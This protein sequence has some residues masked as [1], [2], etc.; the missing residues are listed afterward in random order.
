MATSSRSF[1]RTALAGLAAGAVTIAVAELLAALLDAAGLGSGQG[2]PVLGVGDAAVDRTPGWL[3]DFAISTFG[4]HDK[5]VLL[6]S[7]GVV[8]A[9]LAAAAGV[10][11]GR[12]RGAGVALVIGLGVVAA[13]AVVTRPSAT[14][15]DAVPTALGTASGAVVLRLL[16]VRAAATGPT[17]RRA[18][19]QGA[20]AAGV[21]AVAAG[22][23]S[24]AVGRRAGSAADSRAAVRLP[25]PVERVSVPPG[26]QLPVDGITPWRTAPRDFYRVDTA[27]R[28]P[29]V[30][31]GEWSLRVHG[32]VERELV[33]TYDEL[34][35]RPLV[36]RA[37]TLTCVSN[38]V[39]GQLLGNAVWLGYPVADLLA[40]LGV[41]A[42]ADMVLSTSVD[43][44]TISTPLEHLTRGR[45]ALLAVA[46][47]GE[48]LPP[49]HGFPARLVVPG[50]YGY[51]S[52]TKWVTDLRV[53]RFADDEA[54][55]TSR[56]YSAKAPIKASSRIDVPRSFAKLSA[57]R[58]AVAGVAW[59]QGTGVAAV[60]VRVDRGP[61]RDARL[62][63]VPAD[64]TWVQWVYEWDAEPGTHTLECRLVDADGTVQVEQRH[65]VRPDGS[66]G[67]DS[68]NVTVS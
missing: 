6:V 25:E 16:L 50:L 19:L 22:A 35:S 61:W 33:L 64:T 18:F 42:S 36:E 29:Q 7:I 24:R 55:W 49:E 34:L 51:V 4:A 1:V 65:G 66:T 28:V 40:D 57:G 59:A 62:A 21:L 27:L 39:G 52:A 46:M 26:V 23:A 54:Y 37:I 2:S 41:D 3:K 14:V 53:T 17:S 31:T 15:L 8:L 68:K 10:V 60:Q 9:V 48:P 56:G 63:D 5:L 12:R 30:T 67:L 47:N 11:E 44:M 45:D 58:T 43:G 20:G 13:L 38:E 32:L